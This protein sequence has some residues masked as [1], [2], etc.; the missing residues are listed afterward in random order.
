MIHY[1]PLSESDIYPSMQQHYNNYETIEVQGKMIQV[2]KLE[3]GSYRI[4]QLLSTNPQDYL[5]SSIAPGE[6]IT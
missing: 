4:V 2:E 6:I 3:N 1:T 5:N